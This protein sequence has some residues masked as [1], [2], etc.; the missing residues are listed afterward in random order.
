MKDSSNNP[1]SNVAV[2]ITGATTN[3]T[4]GSTNTSGIF[5]ATFTSTNIA[6]YNLTATFGP[7]AAPITKTIS[8]DVTQ[9]VIPLIVSEPFD[10]GAGLYTTVGYLSGQKPAT[11]GFLGTNAWSGG[12]DS[13]GA[14]TVSSGG[15]VKFERTS[16][17]ANSLKT[18]A[19][20]VTDPSPNPITDNSMR[21]LG[22][23]LKLIST[24]TGSAAEICFEGFY[25]NKAVSI[26]IENIGGG[27][28]KL[29]LALT[30]TTVEPLVIS[31]ADPVWAAR[32]TD[33]GS[34]FAAGTWVRFAAIIQDTGTGVDNVSVYL[35]PTGAE[36]TLASSTLKSTYSVIL[37]ANNVKVTNV[38]LRA[39]PNDATPANNLAYFDD[40]RVGD[41][42]AAVVQ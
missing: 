36:P 31:A 3:P 19:R 1:L 27:Q 5:T 12:A 8:I 4:S 17:L 29:H 24:D 37:K 14:F 40:V 18:C 42:W 11:T 30:G 22:G 10:V 16:G 23:R 38:K 32:F 41:N 2:A 28:Q 7:V 25:N 21:Y 13:F 34:S 35:N 39:S 9:A 20:V 26:G 6:T 15:E 33:G